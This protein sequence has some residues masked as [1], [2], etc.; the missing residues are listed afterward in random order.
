MLSW[1]IEKLKYLKMWLYSLWIIIAIKLGIKV[2]FRLLLQMKGSWLSYSKDLRPYLKKYARYDTFLKWQL[3]LPLI[4]ILSLYKWT[5]FSA[6]I[7]F[8]F[9]IHNW[10]EG[11]IGIGELLLEEGSN[12]N[13]TDYPVSSFALK[14]SQL[15]YL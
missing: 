6:A 3:F 4:I 9:G 14:M 8:V 10:C 13:S 1:S 7:W 5:I 15:A 12:L 2:S 11:F